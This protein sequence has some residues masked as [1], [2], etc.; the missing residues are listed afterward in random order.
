[1]IKRSLVDTMSSRAAR[2]RRKSEKS[3]TFRILGARGTAAVVLGAALS[4]GGLTDAVSGVHFVVQKDLDSVRVLRQ[5]DEHSEVVA[6]LRDSFAANSI[7]KLSRAFPESL[8]TRRNALFDEAWLPHPSKTPA[9][10]AAKRDVFHEE[11]ARINNAIRL[12]FFANAMP[13]GDIIH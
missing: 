8:V 10:A 7:F 4:V 6:N 11:M 1:M 12:E 9:V 2:I 5:D 13:Y 3:R